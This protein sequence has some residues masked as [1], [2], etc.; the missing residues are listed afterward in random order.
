METLLPLIIQV[1]A[2]LIGGNAAGAALKEKSLGT[3]GNS[4]AGGV[5][6]I[7]LGQILQALMGGAA[8]DAGA[9]MAGMDIGKIVTDIVG[10]GAGGA[11]LTAIVGMLKN[12]VS[13]AR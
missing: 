4:I 8:P 10:G 12:Q 3:T 5:G 7:I 2:G 9:A 11:I 6:G 1:V 13:G